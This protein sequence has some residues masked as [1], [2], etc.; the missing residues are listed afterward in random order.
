MDTVQK[1]RTSLSR[2]LL[3]DHIIWQNPIV[4]LESL[5]RGM[6]TLTIS[7][8]RSLVERVDVMIK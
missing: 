7:D 6:H 8:D 4:D 2:T 5:M 1:M 3:G